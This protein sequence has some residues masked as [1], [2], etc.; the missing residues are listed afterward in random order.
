[1]RVMNDGFRPFLDDFVLVYLNYILI[2]NKTWDDHLK[3]VK[4]CLVFRKRRNC[5]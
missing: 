2:F 4:Q 1:M 5:M 3:H